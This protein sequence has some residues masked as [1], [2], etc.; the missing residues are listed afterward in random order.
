VTGSEKS[1]RPEE[2]E[3]FPGGQK[4]QLL[5]PGEKTGNHIISTSKSIQAL[6]AK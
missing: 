5:V 1:S 4:L 2:V 6:F 3:Y